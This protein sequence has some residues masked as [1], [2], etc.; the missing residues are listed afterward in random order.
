MTTCR[1]SFVTLMKVVSHRRGDHLPSDAT[2]ESGTGVGALIR[3]Y[4]TRPR[5]RKSEWKLT[6][7]LS[8][9]D[10]RGRPTPATLSRQMILTRT[11]RPQHCADPVVHPVRCLS[12]VDRSATRTALRHTVTRNL[13]GSGRYPG[14]HGAHGKRHLGSG[15]DC[16]THRHDGGR[17][18]G[19]G[20]PSGA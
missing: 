16:G 10:D 9:V 18:Q 4:R 12:I 11:F 6:D 3:R 5:P 2:P 19:P 1:D 7:A 8:D 20:P 17:G 13:P 15:D 14:V